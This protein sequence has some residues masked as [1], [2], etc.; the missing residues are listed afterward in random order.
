VFHVQLYD[1]SMVLH[2]S[3]SCCFSSHPVHVY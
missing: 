3:A 2:S 1:V